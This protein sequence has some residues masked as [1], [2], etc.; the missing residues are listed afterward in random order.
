MEKEEEGEWKG[1]LARAHGVVKRGPKKEKQRYRKGKLVLI[2]KKTISDRDEEDHTKHHKRSSK[3]KKKQLL[4]ENGGSFASS[5]EYSQTTT[6]QTTQTSRTSFGKSIRGPYK[7]Y[8]EK[9]LAEQEEHKRQCL[10]AITEGR[11]LP[12][13]LTDS[14]HKCGPVDPDEDL[15]DSGSEES[16]TRASDDDEVTEGVEDTTYSSR[17]GSGG[18]GSGSGRSSS[19]RSSTSSSK[20][21]SKKN[22]N[23]VREDF[24]NKSMNTMGS[25]RK[26]LYGGGVRYFTP[27]TQYDDDESE[28][29]EETESEV[30]SEDETTEEETYL[31]GDD[32]EEEEEEESVKSDDA[33]TYSRHSDE[34]S[35]TI[36]VDGSDMNSLF[37]DDT[38]E[39][40]HY[41]ANS[42]VESVTT[43]STAGQNEHLRHDKQEQRKSSSSGGN[44][45]GRGSSGK[46]RTRS[47]KNPPDMAP[48]SDDSL[49]DS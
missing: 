24:K 12:D 41:A 32:D 19:R 37:S 48:I 33:Q 2:L 25:N 11:P 34:E 46:G 43:M 47:G 35:D 1:L 29:E 31:S 26:G 15:Q 10:L 21:K 14:A 49:S 6:S 8:S 28:E 39:S 45:G 5:S 30:E 22:K 42:G 3:A 4:L 20:S 36:H 9:F 38:E 16:E 13:L 7:S 18:S 27:D 40:Y 17:S 44:G 23:N